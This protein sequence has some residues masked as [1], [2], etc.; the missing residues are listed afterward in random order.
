[1]K[2]YSSILGASARVSPLYTCSL[3]GA[4]ELG[5]VHAVYALTVDDLAEKLCDPPSYAYKPTTWQSDRHG[6]LVCHSC[7]R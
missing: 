3:C 6:N 5:D 1:L 7:L 4:Q 2:H